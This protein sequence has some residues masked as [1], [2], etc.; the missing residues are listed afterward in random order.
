MSEKP[1]AGELRGAADRLIL[2][3]GADGCPQDKYDTVW[4][5]KEYLHTVADR[6]EN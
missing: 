5:A 1:T 6:L 2:A 3:W 4:N